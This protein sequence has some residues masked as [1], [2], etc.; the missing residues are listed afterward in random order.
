M[1]KGTVAIVGRPNVGKSTVFNRLIG[2]RK[3][4]V[5]DNPRRD[6]GP[7]LRQGQWLTQS[8]SDRHWRHPDPGSALHR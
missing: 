7:H 5:E 1:N 6:P 4:I 2:E 3:S 8:F